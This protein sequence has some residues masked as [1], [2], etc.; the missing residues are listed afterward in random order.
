MPPPQVPVHSSLIFRSFFCHH[1][2]FHS[3]KSKTNMLVI[4]LYSLWPSALAKD[5]CGKLWCKY[6]YVSASSVAIGDTDIKIKLFHT[7]WKFAHVI[8]LS[9]N[10]LI[11]IVMSSSVWV[12]RVLINLALE[13][14]W[15]ISLDFTSTVEKEVSKQWIY[16]KKISEVPRWNYKYLISMENEPD[17]K[18]RKTLTTNMASMWNLLPSKLRKLRKWKTL[19]QIQS[20]LYPLAKDSSF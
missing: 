7:V 20:L 15:H 2:P 14:S 19:A 10:S 11:Y 6:I 12:E 9:A 1:S 3:F 18:P 5:A 17:L 8:T 16:A 4:K 13:Q